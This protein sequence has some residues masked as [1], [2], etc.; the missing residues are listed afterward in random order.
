MDLS[1]NVG[2]SIAAMERVLGFLTDEVLLDYRYN[3]LTNEYSCC[4]FKVDI[5]GDGYYDND[6]YNEYRWTVLSSLNTFS[7]GKDFI[8]K[9]KQQG[10][11]KIIG[12][13]TGGGMCSVLP[14]VLAGGTAL[15]MSSN[16]SSRHMIKENGKNNY[17]LVEHGLN[18]NFKI[19]Y[20]NYYNNLKIEEYVDLAY[21]Q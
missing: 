8:N 12:N 14:L 17:Y 6:S 7:D 9:V 13:K 2:G 1:L 11:A 18:P 10:L 19:P 20:S 15:A 21:M 3:T 4:H 5:N 16:N